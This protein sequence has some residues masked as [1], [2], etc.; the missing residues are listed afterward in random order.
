MYGW[1]GRIGIVIPCVNITMEPEFNRLAAEIPGLAVHSA[2]MHIELESAE[3]VLTKE[4]L[5]DMQSLA[6]KTVIPELAHANVGVIVYGCTSGSF[7]GG[8][9]WDQKIVESIHEKTGIP[10]T[11]TTTAVVAA[12]KALNVRR[13]ALGTPYNEEITGLGKTF[14]EDEG[15]EVVNT[16]ALDIVDEIITDV[17]QSLAYQLGRRLDT[18]QA[19]CIFISCTSF[20]TI[21]VI[22]TLESDL[23]KPV[24]SANLASFWHA[25]QI[26]AV[27]PRLSGYG[28]LLGEV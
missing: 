17:P 10:A 9:G 26:L 21:D 5:F 23:G 13:V 1:R 4:A 20:P 27:K 18:P 7:M 15:F 22:D 3:K 14:L 16:V 11:T 25:L 24:I 28:S 8:P 6:V 2:R 12:L 19:D